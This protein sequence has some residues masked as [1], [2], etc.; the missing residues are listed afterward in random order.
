M[1]KPNFVC[2]SFIV[3]P[4]H[5]SDWSIVTPKAI[6]RHT[7][8]NGTENKDTMWRKYEYSLV[9][10]AM[11][12]DDFEALQEL[13]NYHNDSGEHI[14]FTY[15][16]WPESTIPVEVNCDPMTRNR[17]AGSGKLLYYQGVT[18]VLTE[19]YPRT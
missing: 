5:P 17:A 7:S 8:L 19:A 18:L 1:I 15:E 16:K 10:R 12:K 11:S 9:Y 3:N 13:I 6:A 2:G 4:E 14:L